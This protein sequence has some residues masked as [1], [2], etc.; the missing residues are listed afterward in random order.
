LAIFVIFDVKMV[1]IINLP[2]VDYI[3]ETNKIA[4]I[5]ENFMRIMIELLI[6]P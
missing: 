6:L 1:L 4:Y 2:P 5:V 3:L